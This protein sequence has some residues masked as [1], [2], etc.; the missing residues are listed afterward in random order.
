MGKLMGDMGARVIKIE[1]TSG[2][3]E[4]C[5]GPFKDDEPHPDRS[6]YFWANNTSK[7]SI[8]LDIESEDGQ[9]IIHKFIAIT[10]IQNSL[11]LILIVW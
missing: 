1:P 10:L 6:L 8:T 3:A 4:R 7:E 2:A 5:I 11:F 9:N